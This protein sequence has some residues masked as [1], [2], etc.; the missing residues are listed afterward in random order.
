MC[1]FSHKLEAKCQVNAG[2]YLSCQWWGN[3]KNKTYLSIIIV[4]WWYFSFV[5][6][7]VFSPFFVIKGQGFL[8]GIRPVGGVPGCAGVFWDS[9]L[10]VFRAR[11]L[12]LEKPGNFRGRRQIF[13]I[14]TCWTVAQFLA[15]KPVNF[16]LLT[17]SFIV[18]LLKFLKLWSW[19]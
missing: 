13:K 8:R 17:D 7:A 3:E 19:M 2:K 11:G 10:G 15:H 12:F 16:A 6:Y 1:R 4:P 9:V 14:K 5:G 18:P